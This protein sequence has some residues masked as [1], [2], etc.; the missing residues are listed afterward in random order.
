M[1]LLM[2]VPDH[3]LAGRDH[4]RVLG[5]LWP[6]FSSHRL[7]L[8]LLLMPFATCESPRLIL[9]RRGAV[10]PSERIAELAFFAVQ[11]RY[12]IS[13]EIDSPD[14]PPLLGIAA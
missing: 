13:L 10:G 4:V 5:A 3:W 7:P 11:T 12:D 2:T 6:E 8:D 1:I 14:W 9:G